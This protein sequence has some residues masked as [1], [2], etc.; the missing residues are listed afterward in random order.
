MT[1]Q[2]CHFQSG[3]TSSQTGLLI[4]YPEKNECGSSHLVITPLPLLPMHNV[5]P[6]NPLQLSVAPN[7]TAFSGFSVVLAGPSSISG[8]GG[9]GVYSS[10][11]KFTG[12][13]PA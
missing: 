10:W 2:K 4:T 6:G 1:V 11:I 8:G 12:A 3:T 5:G 7:S 13:L 9:P